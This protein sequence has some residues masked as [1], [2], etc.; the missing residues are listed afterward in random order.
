[1]KKEA[2]HSQ[3]KNT[4]EKLPNT[5]FC[6]SLFGSRSDLLPTNAITKFWFPNHPKMFYHTQAMNLNLQVPW[7]QLQFLA[8]QVLGKRFLMGE[9]H[10]SRTI[11]RDKMLV[12]CSEEPKSLA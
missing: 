7:K 11:R 2:M 4:T 10:S 5:S 1:M 3:A 12:V 8:S 6:T 9:A